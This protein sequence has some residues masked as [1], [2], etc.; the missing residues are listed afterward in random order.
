MPDQN[1]E[2]AGNNS[3]LRWL[4]VFLIALVSDAV[5][6]FISFTFVPQLG[7]DAATALIIWALMGWRRVWFVAL[8]AEAVPGLSMFPTWTLVVVALRAGGL[9][10]RKN[11]KPGE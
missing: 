3:R 8:I 2:R 7:I 1:D 10:R 5:S 4:I 9:M 6:F 11:Q